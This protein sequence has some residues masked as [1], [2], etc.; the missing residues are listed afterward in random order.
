MCAGRGIAVEMGIRQT[1]RFGRSLRIRVLAGRRSIIACEGQEQGMRRA[2]IPSF[3]GFPSSAIGVR[4]LKPDALSGSRGTPRQETMQSGERARARSRVSSPQA[5]SPRGGSPCRYR[6]LRSWRHGGNAC[7]QARGG[8]TWPPHP[9][10]AARAVVIAK[11]RAPAA[12]G[13]AP[14]SHVCFVATLH[15]PHGVVI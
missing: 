10:L 5:G 13:S 2:G 3:A 14:C 12:A 6:V 11:S 1:F 4:C 15:P 9:L 8:P 7:P